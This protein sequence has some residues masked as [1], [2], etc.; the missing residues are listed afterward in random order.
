MITD[1]CT[2]QAVVRCDACKRRVPDAP[3]DRLTEAQLHGWKRC[4]SMARSDDVPDLHFC[5]A[6]F[7]AMEQEVPDER[8]ARAV[9]ASCRAGAEALFGGEKV[10][11]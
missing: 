11:P 8:R 2:L 5:P 6:C 1:P 7:E 9:E 4:S 10:K 3:T